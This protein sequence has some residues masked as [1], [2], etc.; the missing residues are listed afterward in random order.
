MGPPKEACL[1]DE[2]PLGMLGTMCGAHAP[3]D[4]LTMALSKVRANF[5]WVVTFNYLF[6]VA[7]PTLARL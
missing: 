1:G 7:A 4:T 2:A 3:M 5:G 6:S